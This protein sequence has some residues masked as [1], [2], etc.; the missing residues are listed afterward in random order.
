M[1]G[2]LLIAGR[3]LLRLF[4]NEEIVIENGLMVQRFLVPFFVTYVCIEVFSGTM[5][6]AGESLRD[7]TNREPCFGTKCD[8]PIIWPNENP[9]YGRMKIQNITE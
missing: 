6:G 1:S 2:T 7:C 8:K 5:R 4:A 9:K 3:P